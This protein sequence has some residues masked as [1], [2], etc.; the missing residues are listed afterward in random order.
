MIVVLYLCFF[1]LGVVLVYNKFNT[2][3]KIYKVLKEN[4]KIILTNVVGEVKS[5]ES[6]LIEKNDFDSIKDN[7]YDNARPFLN[8]VELNG[9][10][11]SLY[12]TDIEVQLDYVN[13]IM[14][15]SGAT[16]SVTFRLKE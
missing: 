5:N 14:N 6:I 12:N 4:K 1:S 8:S 15:T 10:N 16:Q 2:R 11:H 7:I 9:L 13:S 3:K